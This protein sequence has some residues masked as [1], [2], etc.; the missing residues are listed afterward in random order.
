M[1]EEENEVVVLLKFAFATF[2]ITYLIR[3]TD[4]PFGIFAVFRL[5]MGIKKVP[6]GVDEFLEDIG[7]GFFAKLFSCFFRF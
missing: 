2:G 4:G 1:V 6:I 7:D 3:Y 5:W